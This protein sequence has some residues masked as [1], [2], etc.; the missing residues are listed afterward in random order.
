VSVESQEEAAD[1]LTATA[2]HLTRAEAASLD[3]V[4]AG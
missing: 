4:S 3:R 2:V 1:V